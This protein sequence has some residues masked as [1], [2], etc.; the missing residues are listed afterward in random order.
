MSQNAAIWTISLGFVAVMAVFHY[1]G[2]PLN[3]QHSYGTGA[4]VALLA[5][6]WSVSWNI[7]LGRALFEREVEAPRRHWASTR[8]PFLRLVMRQPKAS[9]GDA[10]MVLWALSAASTGWWC[11]AFLY[12]LVRWAADFRLPSAVLATEQSCSEK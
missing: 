5:L 1:V 4:I 8:H 11:L 10:M 6:P 7:V 2:A 9:V 12:F 3:A